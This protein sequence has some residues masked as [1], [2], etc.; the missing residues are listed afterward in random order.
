[1]R[2][3]ALL[4]AMWLMLSGG[5]QASTLRFTYEAS[6]AELINPYMGNAIWAAEE[7]EH[8]QPFTLVYA[9]LTWAELEPIEGT[10]DF[11][12]F[13]E[14][15][16]FD[17]WRAVGKRMIL[18]FV[19]DLPGEKKHAD[20]PDWLRKR[21]K[22]D[23]YKVSYGRGYCP[24]YADEA[25]IAEHKKVIAALGER[26]DGDPFVAFVE[27]GSLGHWGEWH[28]NDG[29]GQMPP[30]DVRDRYARAYTD[31][32]A[33]TYLLMRRPFAFAAQN[34][35]GL[36]NDAAGRPDS[37]QIWLDW[38]ENG[39]AY[40]ATDE[41]NALAPMP[42][43]WKTQP[44][45]GELA[46]SMEAEEY[47]LDGLEET[48]SLFVRSHASWIAPGSFVDVERGGDMQAALDE[49]MRKLGYRLRIETASVGED[50]SL[51]LAWT[52][53][54]CA[55]FYFDW[56]PCVRLRRADGTRTVLALDMKLSDVLP[57]ETLSATVSLPALTGAAVVEAAILDP[58]T[59]RP[60]VALAMHAAC[61]DGWYR[62]FEMM[63]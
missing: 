33:H 32:F 25:L 16:Q 18:R 45:G 19:M 41:P 21:T 31:A 8:E 57:G 34:G 15:C 56:Q 49:L 48:I 36:Y 35:L 54:G 29:A 24:D 44:I 10:Y 60:G 63:P 40:D 3:L 51:T 50:G 47:L 9:N 2:K 17:K 11:G 5:A 4:L 12:A 30:E 22:G 28:I 42:D 23:F 14:R 43:A 61:E 62:L 46:T 6:D 59:G 39:G 53:D 37:T 58:L 13:E 52:N 20:I 55:P 7:D 38:I 26:Y 27:L 1:M